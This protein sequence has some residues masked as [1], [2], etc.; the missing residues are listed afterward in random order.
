MGGQVR[1]RSSSSDVCDAVLY[2]WA[3]PGCGNGSSERGVWDDM[4]NWYQRE[5][6]TGTG[7]HQ[8]HVQL[9]AQP[10]W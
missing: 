6:F 3:W 2:C 10:I 7:K 4:N 5:I 1:N 8:N 9:E